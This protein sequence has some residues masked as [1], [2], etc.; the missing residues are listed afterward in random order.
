M[1]KFPYESEY[2]Y[3]NRRVISTKK[4]YGKY[5]FVDHKGQLVIPAKY[6]NIFDFMAKNKITPA[7]E[8]KFGSGPWYFINING[9]R[10]GSWIIDLIHK[11]EEKDNSY[12][13]TQ[14]GARFRFAIKD[15]KPSKQQ[16][17][18]NYFKY[19]IIDPLYEGL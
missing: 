18:I 5:G 2:I 12:Y 13:I 8:G 16:T 6:T 17:I 19:G 11:H 10:V 3:L 1:P 9:N 7:T 4:G 15:D 14:K